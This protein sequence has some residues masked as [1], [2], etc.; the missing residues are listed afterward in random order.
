MPLVNDTCRTL[1]PCGKNRRMRVLISCIPSEGH[2]R[3]LLPLAQALAGRGHDVVF[4]TAEAWRP[5]VEEEGFGLLAAGISEHEARKQLLPAF[6]DVFAL[7]PE[8]RRPEAFTAIFALTHAPQKLA[9]LVDVARSWQ[10]DVIVWDSADLAAPVVATVLGI[11]AVN[12]SFGAMLPLAV[13]S[14]AEVGA[15]SLWRAHGLEPAP[16]AGAFDGLYVDIS[17]PS[18]TVEEPLGRSVRLG[19]S[20]RLWEGAGLARRA[21]APARLRDNGDGRQ[22]ARALPPLARRAR[23]RRLGLVTLGEGAI[24]R[25]SPPCRRACGSSRSSR[26]PTCCRPAT[27]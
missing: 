14:R 12:H 10:P 1:F 2:F 19:R 23:R 8:T 25:S 20:H 4:A 22:P 18:F 24:P 5:R 16:Y 7:P 13:L 15:A 9:A 11:P 6:A 26:R 21:R 17:P 27:R 3:P